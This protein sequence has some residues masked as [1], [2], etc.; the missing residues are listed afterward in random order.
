MKQSFP[1][2][3]RRFSMTKTSG[4]LRRT[5]CSNVSLRFAVRRVCYRCFWNLPAMVFRQLIHSIIAESPESG[6]VIATVMPRG[7]FVRKCWWRMFQ[8]MPTPMPTAW[9]IMFDL[10]PEQHQHQIRTWKAQPNGMAIVENLANY[11]RIGYLFASPVMVELYCWFTEF[12]RV[13]QRGDAQQRYLQFIEWVTPKFKDSL[14]LRYFSAP[15]KHLKR[16]VRR[17]LASRLIIAIYAGA[18]SAA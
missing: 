5:D 11:L 3:S 18:N 10:L 7:I 6:C 1:A 12:N 16:C 4:I 14:I 8:T 13:S 15:S 2:G 17:L 9:G